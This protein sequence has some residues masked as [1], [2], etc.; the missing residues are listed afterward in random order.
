MEKR[1]PLVSLVVPTKNR[2]PYLIK[3]IELLKTFGLGSEFELVIQDNNE[4]NSSF[5]AYLEENPYE[6][7]R[8]FFDPT[9]VPIGENCDKA[10]N[11]SFGKYVCFIGD[12]DCVTK[13]FMPCVKW[14]EE[15]GVECVF[16]RRIMY[17]WPDYCDKGDERAAVHYEPFSDDVTF[18]K[19]ESVLRELLKSGCVGIARVPMIYHGIVNRKVL[20]RIWDKCGTF[21][22]GAS[23]DIASGV[24][25][26]LT[27]DKYASFRFPI[28]IAGNSRTGGGGQKVMKHHAE[29][30]FSKL[31]FL[32]EKTKTIWDNRIPRIWSNA[33]IWCESV[34]EALNWWKREDLVEQINFDKLYVN[35]IVNYF[36]YRKMAYEL[37]DKKIKLFVKAAY[38]GVV[39]LA[40]NTIKSLLRVLHINRDTRVKIT[41]INDINEL[42]EYFESKGLVFSKYT[43]NVTQK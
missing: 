43:F 42:C 10:I 38:G 7:L 18:Y 1:S 15:N 39:L 13:N 12:D 36:Y 40:K 3:L 9:P 20:D 8:Y 25:L 14:M 11:H 16:P 24:S 5:L 27:I 32:P 17:F 35:F 6:R 34:V 22:P 28:I 21:F 2:Y 29:L 19:T 33:T 31:P 30:D 37:T 41:G 23:P 26:C 4:D